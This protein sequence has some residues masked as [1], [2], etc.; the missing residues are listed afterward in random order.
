MQNKIVVKLKNPL[1]DLKK[2]EK[3]VSYDKIT[4]D[5]PQCRFNF[6]YNFLQYGNS[7]MVVD[8]DLEIIAQYG[9]MTNKIV[10]QA[11]VSFLFGVKLPKEVKDL[12]TEYHFT[13]TEM[14]VVKNG[15]V[16]CKTGYIDP[17]Y[18]DVDFVFDKYV[19]TQPTNC[20]VYDPDMLMLAIDIVPKCTVF[21]III[22]GTKMKL[23]FDGGT[24][25]LMMPQFRK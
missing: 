18:P 25:F 21:N 19:K 22:G 5:I 12:D 13:D 20:S 24:A 14:S 10:K 23:S 6:E 8:F 7:H 9:K 4:Q 1:I 2:A 16:Y 11:D 17:T 3:L 15:I